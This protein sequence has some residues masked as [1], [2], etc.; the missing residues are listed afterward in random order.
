MSDAKWTRVGEDM[1]IEGSLS[2]GSPLVVEGEIVGDV[3]TPRQ[4]EIAEDGLIHGAVRGDEV[5]VAGKIEGPVTTTGR[6][7]I[8]A[9]G[10]VVGDVAVKSIL[11]EEGGS[12]TG[13][14][15]MG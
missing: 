5:I 14:C 7:L 11:V 12:L 15:K 2:T 9:S 4:I 10:S 3:T 1:R 13:R 6:L 8:L